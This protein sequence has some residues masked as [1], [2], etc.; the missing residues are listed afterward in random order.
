MRAADNFHHREHYIDVAKCENP[1]LYTNTAFYLTRLSNEY[2]EG[3][4]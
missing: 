2:A 4:R 3:V 1:R